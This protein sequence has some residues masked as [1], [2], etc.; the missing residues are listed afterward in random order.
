MKNLILSFALALVSFTG[1]SQEPDGVT[2]TVTVENIKN[3]NGKASFALHTVDTFMKG[4]GIMN[5]ESEIKDGKVVVTFENVKPGDY[6]I[7]GMHD[8]NEN[9]RMDFED[10]GMPKEGYGMSNNVMSF[11]PPQYGDAKFTVAKEPIE[12]KIRF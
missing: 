3:D 1:F 4:A 2:I 11:G 6:A 5:A 9:G 8:E 12:M 10:N 7:M